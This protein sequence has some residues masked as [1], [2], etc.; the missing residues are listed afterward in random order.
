MA[1]WECPACGRTFGKVGR[2]H[3][4][5]PG[6][7]VEEY[8]AGGHPLTG[9]VHERVLAHLETL[10]GELIV[11]P[12]GAGIMYKHDSMIAM[13]RSKTKWVALGLVLRRRLDSPRVSLKVTENGGKFW[14]VF[15]IHDADAID[16]EMCDW[17]TEAFLREPVGEV[18][19]ASWDPMVP[20]DIDLGP[21]A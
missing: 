1:T 8:V 4:C 11:D 12:V 15:N 21:L 20:D 5:N 14:H 13:L 7:T 19:S 6:V 2:P 18:A 16:D 17:L 10:D 9:P 3:M